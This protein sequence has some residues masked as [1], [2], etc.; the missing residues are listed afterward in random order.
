MDTVAHLQL[1]VEALKFVQSAPPTLA[2]TTLPVLSKPVACTSTKVPKFSGETSWDQY[3][4]VFDAIVRSNGWDD[5]T[6]AL[7][8]LSHLEGDTLNVAL[9]V[10]AV[11]RA[12]CT[13]LVGALTE[14]YGSPGRL[15]D[16]RRQFERTTRQEGE[17][18]STFAI[19]LETLAAKAFW[20]GTWVR[21]HDC[22]SYGTGLSPVTRA[23]HCADILAAFPRRLPFGTLWT[24]AGCG[25]ATQTLA[26]G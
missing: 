13:G 9:L 6:V 7:Q 24:D 26:S 16:Y 10:S 17:D 8:L 20:V 14:H 22:D 5:A 19:A 21:T 15:A 2:K 25:R 11:R 18:P 3:R 23:A 12:T 4:Q 1:A